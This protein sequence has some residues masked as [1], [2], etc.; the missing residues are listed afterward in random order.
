MHRRIQH[1]GKEE[2]EREKR[3]KKAKCMAQ[4]EHFEKGDVQ[5][6][7]YRAVGF[8]F[9]FNHFRAMV[10]LQHTLSSLY[11]SKLLSFLSH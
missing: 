10:L 6:C 8:F 7:H 3:G 2:G 9:F 11:P 1:L 4:R 5:G